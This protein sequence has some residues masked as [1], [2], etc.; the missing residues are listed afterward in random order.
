MSRLRH[1]CIAAFIGAAAHGALAAEY[2]AKVVRIIVPFSPGAAADAVTRVVAKKLT[3]YWGKQV[4][5]DNRP[6]VPGV[7]IAASSPADGY[8]LLLGAGSNI[9][10]SPLMMAKPPYNPQKD[11]APVSR[12]VNIP[13]I[14]TTH[15]S[16]GVKNVKELIA[17]AKS[18]PGQLNY[19]SSGLGAPNHLAMELFMVLT[20]TNMVHVPYKGAA[21]SV[22]E[23]VG[24]QLQLGFNAIPSV[25]AHVQDGRLKALAVSSA[26][27]ARALPDL[28]TIAESAVPGFEYNIWY[29]LFAPAR[30]PAVIVAKISTD[31]QRALNE[32][33]VVQQ[34]TAQGTEPAP[35]T[36][37][38][39]AQYIR[40]D[41][42][43]WTK[44]VKERNL[45]LE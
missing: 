27:R 6:G 30:T 14:L 23:M 43:R 15:P 40:Q 21:P 38:E 2:P 35:S 8:T 41:T 34:L 36:S 13:P 22:T 16:L 45:K 9:V 17:L 28:P 4:I 12:V 1:L 26:K 5:L 44:I 31:V 19:S 39:L 37:A 7:Q 18:K 24:G 33:D 10:T 11:F 20:G 29:G 25:L 3:D 42:A 32:P